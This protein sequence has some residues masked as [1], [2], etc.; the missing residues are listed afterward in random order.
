MLF[1]LAKP[2]ILNEISQLYDD[3]NDYLD[4][5]TNYP[6]WKKGIYPTRIDAEAGIHANELF[7]LRKEGVIVGSVIVNHSQ[8]PTYA[9]AIWQSEAVGDE[10]LVIRTLVTHP[11]YMK[12]GIS[13]ILLACVKEHA[14]SL[15]CKSIR[16]DVA[17]QNEPAIT[18]YEKCGYT[19]VG[20]V[21]LGLPYE[22]LKW[23][24]LYELVL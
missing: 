13:Q 16:L 24:R 20:T 3:L 10:V 22:H 17:V 18:L 1:E 19:Y 4:E 8:E 2:H 7:V 11:N 21:D 14:L 23:F 5:H 9:G 15:G 6:G 12:Q